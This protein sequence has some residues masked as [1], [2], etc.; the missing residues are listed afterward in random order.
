MP[1]WRLGGELEMLNNLLHK[2]RS[3]WKAV[4]K[5]QQVADQVAVVTALHY[6]Q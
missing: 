2:S 1:S 3:Q 5:V 4:T 6:L